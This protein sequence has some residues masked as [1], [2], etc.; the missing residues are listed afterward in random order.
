MPPFTPVAA[1]TLAVY[2]LSTIWR[3]GRHEGGVFFGFLN[4]KEPVHAICNAGP[5]TP[6]LSG[7]KRQSP[8]PDEKAETLA[9]FGA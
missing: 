2:P 6:D 5:S 9:A 3:I 8:E 1:W 7:D 4:L